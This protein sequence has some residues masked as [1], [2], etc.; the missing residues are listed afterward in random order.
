MAGGDSLVAAFANV[1]DVTPA[2]AIISDPATTAPHGWHGATKGIKLAMVPAFFALSGFLV[3]GSAFR[4]KST[5]TFL[6]HRSLRIFPALAVE[7]ALSAFLLGPLLT[8]LPLSQYFADPALRHY[9]GNAAGFVTFV[10]PGVF[11]ANPVP[12]I[13]N[14]NLWTLPGEFYCYLIA[15][16]ALATRILYNRTLFTIAVGLMT[17]VLAAMHFQLGNSVTGGPFPTHV[18]V[19]YFFVGM[20][21]YH[22]RDR[23]PARPWIFAISVVV[24]YATLS[25]DSLIYI[26]PLFVTYATIFVGMIAFPKSRLLSSG[27]Y[28][29]G[30]YLYG[31]PIAQAL[32]AVF[33]WFEGQPWSLVVV[34]GALTIAFAAA[35]WHLI[36]KHALR[37]KKRL[38]ARYFPTGTARSATA[39][40]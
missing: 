5:S 10:L 39:E 38:P 16:A 30:V 25:I 28:S 24:T 34:A 40:A 29:Y 13:V 32:V 14:A 33:P 37:Q 19:Y 11:E 7:V 23:I 26:A 4:L 9:L 2:T 18:I 6:A 27:D 12:H 1:G 20:L 17:V 21:F 15:G 8:T 36:E 3:S 35:S 22:W 31:F